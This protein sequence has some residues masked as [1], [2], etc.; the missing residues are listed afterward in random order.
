MVHP[1]GEP[2]FLQRP[3]GHFLA[4]FRIYTGVNQGQFNIPQ[5]RRT[6]KQV[7]GLKDK[8]DLT[9]ANFRQLVVVHL[10]HVFAIEFV[11]TGGRRIETAQHIHEGRFAA[12]AGAH[13]RDVFIAMDPQ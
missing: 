13:D 6:R 8:S 12:A 4:R 2:D 5:T 10:R 7:E 11:M 9:V 3:R 1:V